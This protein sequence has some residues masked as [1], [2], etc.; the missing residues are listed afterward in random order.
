M[1]NKITKIEVF[2]TGCASCKKMLEIT[3]S[4]VDELGIGV[5]VEYINDM[6]KIVENNILSLPALA[7]NRKMTLTGFVP[8][9]EKVKELINKVIQWDNQTDAEKIKNC[10]CGGNC[11]K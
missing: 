9:K 7:I 6:Q 11:D 5:E 4:A 8:D 1:S 2:G 10:C 3:K